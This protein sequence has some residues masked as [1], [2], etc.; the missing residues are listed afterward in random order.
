ML[1]N[2]TLFRKP[3]TDYPNMWAQ[4]EFKVSNNEYAQQELEK[5]KIKATCS[6]T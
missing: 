4:L 2:T 5:P 6:P 3:I 1:D